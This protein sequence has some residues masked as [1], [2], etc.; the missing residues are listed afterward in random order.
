MYN[1][2]RPGAATPGRSEQKTTN[3]SIKGAVYP[4]MIP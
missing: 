3:T 2:N 1:K 4:F